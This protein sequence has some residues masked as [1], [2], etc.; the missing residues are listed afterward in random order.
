MVVQGSH[1]FS[2][3]KFKDFSGTFQGLLNIFQG[4]FMCML[5]KWLADYKNKLR[6]EGINNDNLWS[7]YHSFYQIS[8][9]A[10]Q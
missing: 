8:D 4:P 5:K 2:N 3:T 10:Y 7:F 1:S 6:P 9:H